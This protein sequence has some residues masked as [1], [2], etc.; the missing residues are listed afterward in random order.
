MQPVAYTYVYNESEILPWTVPAMLRQGVNVYALDNW[1]TDNTREV[2]AEMAYHNPGRVQL[3]R[4]PDEPPKW[5]DL[6]VILHRI[7]ALQAQYTPEWAL[8]FGADEVLVPCWPNMTMAEA[9]DRV[10][11]E[12]YNAVN[13]QM[14]Q[15]WPVDDGWTP[16]QDPEQYFRYYTPGRRDNVRAWCSGGKPARIR[17]GTH[18]V[19]FD[20][21]R[22]Y[23]RSFGIK[24][25]SFRT[26]AQS[27]RR[28]FDERL[29]RYAPKNRA[30]GWHG[31]YDHLER[32]HS[33]I[34]DPRGLRYFDPD[35]YFEGDI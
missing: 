15:F 25:Y 2:I 3:E 12:G 10:Q 29:P 7:E 22:V 35:T 28:V 13:F 30:K 21:L 6:D 34:K 16:A 31:H 33:F 1:S 11:H 4:F 17:D 20:G 8:L 19:S 26:Q 5:F 18:G 32:G 9:L 23:P 14:I 24:H 27:E